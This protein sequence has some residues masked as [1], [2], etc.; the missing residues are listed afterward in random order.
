MT[1]PTPPALRADMDGDGKSGLGDVGPWCSALWEHAQSVFMVP[2]DAALVVVLVE[3]P[4]FAGGHGMT[5][6]WYGGW[7]SGLVS[8]GV[9]LSALVGAYFAIERFRR[10][11]VTS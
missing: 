5:T 10:P 7:F 2:G 9:W 11:D 6:D 4:G 3:F 1:R 8:T